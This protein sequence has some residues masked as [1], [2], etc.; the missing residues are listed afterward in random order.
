V[1]Y[2]W[3][4][5]RIESTANRISLALASTSGYFTI[6][7]YHHASRSAVAGVANGPLTIRS[8]WHLDNPGTYNGLP[9]A[10]IDTRDIA[11]GTGNIVIAV[12]DTGIDRD[13]PDLASVF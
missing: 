2:L 5:R 3:Q 11:T 4:P 1:C 6:H 8:Q 12:I 13:H 10:D 7:G 9:D